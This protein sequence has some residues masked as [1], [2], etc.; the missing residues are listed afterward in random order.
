MIFQLGAESKLIFK[1]FFDGAEKNAQKKY[2]LVWKGYHRIAH[3]SRE[4]HANEENIR[5]VA[6]WG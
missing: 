2:G 6:N 4:I 5:I 1:D 3:A